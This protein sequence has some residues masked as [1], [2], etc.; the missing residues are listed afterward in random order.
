MTDE[1]KEKFLKKFGKTIQ[2]V[3]NKEK[4]SQEELAARSKIHRTYMGRIERGESNPPI[5]TVFKIVKGLHV[6]VVTF[7]EKVFR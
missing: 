4:I 6:E 2:E 7:L 5:Y 3:R 1:A